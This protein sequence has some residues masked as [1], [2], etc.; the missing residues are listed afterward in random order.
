[1][2]TLNVSVAIVLPLNERQQLAFAELQPCL[3][4]VPVHMHEAIVRYALWGRRPGDFL[5]AV[6]AN[7]FTGAVLRADDDN[8][9]AIHAWARLLHNGVPAGCFGSAGDVDAWV[10][11]H[12][13]ADADQ[14][15]VMIIR[16]RVFVDEV[17]N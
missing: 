11:R 17:P 12:G 15:N 4:D 16:D 5:Q 3:M 6:L 10:A 7:D 2:A 8:L 14:I 13:L 1:M 9:L